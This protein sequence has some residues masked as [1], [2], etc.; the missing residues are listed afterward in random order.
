MRR[1]LQNSPILLWR[2]RRATTMETGL[3]EIQAK[4][5]FENR[6]N[7]DAQQSLICRLFGPTHPNGDGAESDSEQR[8]QAV[9]SGPKADAC[10]PDLA[11]CYLRLAN[12]PTFPLD[13]LSRYEPALWRQAAQ[14]IFTLAALYRRKP[15]ETGRRFRPTRGSSITEISEND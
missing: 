7:R 5:L 8:S 13:R 9:M 6:K 12:L 14:T 15:W 2:I 3:F 10:S 11:Q 1:V 4:N